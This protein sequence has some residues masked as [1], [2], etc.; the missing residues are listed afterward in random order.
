MDIDE[1]NAELLFSRTFEVRNAAGMVLA[2]GLSCLEDARGVAAGILEA[3][4]ETELVV[5]S[6]DVWRHVVIRAAAPVVGG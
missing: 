6:T 5:V 3:H 2:R 4:P 1:T